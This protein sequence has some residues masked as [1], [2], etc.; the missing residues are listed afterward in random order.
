MIE[1]FDVKITPFD[2]FRTIHV[3]LPDSY[4]Y[5]DERYPVMY[6]FDGHNYF[7]MKMR[8]MVSHGA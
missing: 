6:M 5:S 1:K 4:F 3:Y 7:M 8:L 2:L